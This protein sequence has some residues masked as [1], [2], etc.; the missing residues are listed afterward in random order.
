[1]TL[2]LEDTGK[3]VR[4]LSGR[5]FKSTTPAA[6]KPRFADYVL[7]NAVDELLN[8]RTVPFR[9]PDGGYLL[10]V[11]DKKKRLEHHAELLE[12]DT[13]KPVRLET[14]R[15][16]HPFPHAWTA[17]GDRLFL[18]CK[19]ELWCIERA[20]YESRCIEQ[21]ASGTRVPA[22]AIAGDLLAWEGPDRFTIRSLASGKDIVQERRGEG[23]VAALAGR[24][25]LLQ[26]SQGVSRLYAV[27][28][29]E[30]QLVASS[31]QRILAA[32]EEGGEAFVNLSLASLSSPVGVDDEVRTHRLVGLD[33]LYPESW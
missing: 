6:K 11:P 20:N 7:P 19:N 16:F 15:A 17:A 27:R 9:A 31:S 12:P 28:G 14:R 23:V 26:S 32:W 24:R 29:E 2:P 5:L 13:D 30:A 10:F 18:G 33:A 22:I 25:F 21:N 1:M 3:E 8:P 4:A